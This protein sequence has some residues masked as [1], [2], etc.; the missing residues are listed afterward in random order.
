MLK[1][2]LKFHY[3]SSTALTC[4]HFNQLKKM[5][6]CVQCTPKFHFR[7]REFDTT[8]LCVTILLF[9]FHFPNFILERKS[10]TQLN[11]VLPYCSDPCRPRREIHSSISILAYVAFLSFN[12]IILLGRKGEG[13]LYIGACAATVPG[14]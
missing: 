6:I 8:Q 7:E 5:L 9:Y 14:K 3:K 10:S 11:Y 1:R 2:R 13:Y 4:Q 12:P